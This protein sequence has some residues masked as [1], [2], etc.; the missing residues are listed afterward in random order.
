MYH[1]IV[2]FQM[3]GFASDFVYLLYA[4]MFSQLLGLMCAMISTVTSFVFVTI[5]YMQSKSD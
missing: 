1:M 3:T 4:V 2:E 5:L